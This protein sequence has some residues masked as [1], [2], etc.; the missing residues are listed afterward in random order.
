MSGLQRSLSRCEER[1]LKAL[2]RE[3][4]PPYEILPSTKY[5]HRT[6][7]GVLR[8]REFDILLFHPE[9]GILIIEVKGGGI[10]YDG[11]KKQWMRMDC[12]EGW[13][14]ID[15]DPFEQ[16]QSAATHLYKAIKDSGIF[17]DGKVPIPVGHAVFFPEIRWTSEVLPLHASKEVILDSSSFVEIGKKIDDIFRQ[18]TE[19]YH[20]ALTTQQIKAIKSQ[21]LY[22]SCCVMPTLKSR[23]ENDEV[24]IVKL[25]D[26]QYKILD[27]LEETSRIAIKG[28]AGTGK[29]L[30]AMEK[31]RRLYREGARVLL[32]CFNK[33]LAEEMAKSLIG[34]SDRIHVRHFHKL[35]FD[36]CRDAHVDFDVPEEDEAR[37]H[38]WNEE[39]PML[40]LEAIEE[41]K[42]SFDAIIVDEGQD[43][44]SNWWDVL[45]ELLN[46]K[47]K[48]TFY[49]FYDP[50]Q[51]IYREGVKLPVDIAPIVL[52]TNCRNTRNIGRLVSRFGLP[53]MKWHESSVDGDA[54]KFFKYK[55]EVEE[56]ER[57]QM[58][59]DDL[60][61][62]HQLIPNDIVCLST[63]S[64]KNSCFRETADIAGVPLTEDLLL[65]GD[66]IRFSS[67]HKFKGLESNVVVMCD[68]SEYSDRFQ[69]EHFY[70]GASRAKHRLFVF[71]DKKW[72][73]DKLAE[74]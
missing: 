48:G 4:K 12:D 70:V 72:S 3:L 37:S 42:H 74:M 38:F 57:V 22:P 29:T 67:L 32:A 13:T 58:L 51:M 26:E 17:I 27:M 40:L 50:C 20:K 55:T 36:F 18:F 71:H 65:P 53:D 8:D 33:P 16:A 6:N 39:A 59:V 46:D 68:V 10:R 63:H 45:L 19:P 47:A 28:Y 44:R 31:A 41:L 35:C 34:M 23:I 14:H 56:L 60:M 21:F 61:N 66:N 24:D 62:K 64:R 9:K 7:T 43:F 52:K 1:V 5:V 15:S 11:E 49:I 2:Q 73:L 69:K 54:P 25:T 30:L